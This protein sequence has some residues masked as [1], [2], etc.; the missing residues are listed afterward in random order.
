MA[1][2]SEQIIEQIR[3]TADIVEVV[4]GYVQ[5]KKRGRNYFGLCPFHDEKT[6]SFSVSPERQI[7]KCFGC[8]VGGG[9]INF[10][11]EIEGMEF[12]NAVKHLADQYSIEIQI[13]ETPGQSKDFITQL[14]DLHEKTS[15]IFL[16]NLGT[17]EGGKVLAYLE[18][19]GISKDTIQKFK[20]GYSLK[21]KDALLSTF[22]KDGVKGDVMKQSGLF[23]DTKSGYMDR[24]NGRIVFSIPNSS[25]KVAAFAGRVFESDDPA[26]Y[27]NSPVTPIYNKSKILYGLHETKQVIRESKSVIVVEGYLDFLQ[28][29]QSGIH[30]CVAVSGTAFTDQHA[31]QLKRFCNNVYLAYDG[32]SAGK[33]AAIRAG[34][35]LLRSGI[36]AFII[37]IPEGLDP[38]DWVKRDGNTPFLEEVKKGEKM[39]SFHF[40]NYKGDI[41]T[42]SGKTAFVND[43][44]MEVIQINNPV[45]RELQSRELSELIG[46]SPESIFQA[47]HTM[48]EKQQRRKKYQ[49]RN[50]SLNPQTENKKQFLE[51]DLIRLCFSKDL[52][53]RKYLFDNVNQDW[54]VTAFSKTIFEKVYIHLHSENAPEVGLIMNE[55]NESIYRDELAKLVFDLEKLTPTLKSAQNCVLR[56]EQSWINVHIQSLREELKN[57]ESAG[58]DPIPIMKKIEELQG[59]KKNL[60]NEQ[61]ADE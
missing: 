4:S 16:K 14:F 28:L 5:L 43:V 57:A 54:L 13:D 1:R 47:L 45:D 9:V 17:E 50:Q 60:S 26:K 31:L 36:S 41:S 23:I 46:V 21:Q 35:V 8:S 27:V 25:G 49:K 32:D 44:L 56:L 15:N 51:N 42:T 19:R 18:S 39:L 61:T 29:Y 55:L 10:I 20:L 52:V 53:I 34:Y 22:R 33:A 48:L 3:S 11:M 59:Q 30:N 40:Q 7:Y 2:I 58:R 38:D 12:I 6:A 37:N 24:F